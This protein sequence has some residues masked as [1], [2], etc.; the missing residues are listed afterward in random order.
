MV[1]KLYMNFSNGSDKKYMPPV[2]VKNNF[3]QPQKYV[4]QQQNN[5]TRQ[6]VKPNQKPNFNAYV[7]R[8]FR[9]VYG[10]MNMGARG[11][12]SCGK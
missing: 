1:F 12:C 5:S 9:S 3:L 2:L 8:N 11:G 4:S 7:N 6:L 10:A